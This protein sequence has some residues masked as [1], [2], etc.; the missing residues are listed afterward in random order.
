MLLPPKSIA[1]ARQGAA[2]VIMDYIIIVAG[3]KGM[4]MGADIPKQFLLLGGRPIL[5]RTM[6]QFYNYSADLQLIV[7]LPK[8]QQH[9][10]KQLCN[11][12]NFTIPHHIVDGG[13]TRFDSCKH[14]LAAIPAG[15]SGVVGIHDGVRPFVTSDLIDR[16]FTAAREHAAALPALLPHDSL[17]HVGQKGEAR[18]VPREQYRLVQTPQVFDIALLQ[19]AYQQ[20]FQDHFTDDASV[21]EALGERITLVEGARENIKI[22][23]PFDLKV[24]ETLL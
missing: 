19:R 8:A 10:W 9:H 6:E 23:T 22:T 3:G 13:Q 11:D 1:F 4:R 5:M 16:C 18:H 21:V 2:N 15:E 12:Y 17:C 20:P 24:A 7:V 14:G